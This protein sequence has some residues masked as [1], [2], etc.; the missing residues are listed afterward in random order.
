M[1]R[2]WVDLA[3]VCRKVFG[4]RGFESDSAML[5]LEVARHMRRLECCTCALDA[6]TFRRAICSEFIA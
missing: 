5:E 6:E 4:G 2:G 3:L 1:F